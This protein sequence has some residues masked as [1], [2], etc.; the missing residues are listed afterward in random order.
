MMLHALKINLII[1]GYE[2][3][4][5]N[6]NHD[7]DIS[8]SDADADEIDNKQVFLQQQNSNLK[9]EEEKDIIKFIERIQ[10]FDK[11]K[12]KLIKDSNGNTEVIAYCDDEVKRD[13]ETE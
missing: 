13:T 11:R 6:D 7:N 8:K 1:F 5:L 12:F 3:E 4:V 9:K 10:N 2:I